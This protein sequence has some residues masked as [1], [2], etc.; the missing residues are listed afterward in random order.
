MHH[1]CKKI[2]VIGAGQMGVGIACVAAKVAKLPVVLIDSKQDQLDKGL[3][4]IG[5]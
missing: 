2:G 5:M 3:K 1:G 4:Y